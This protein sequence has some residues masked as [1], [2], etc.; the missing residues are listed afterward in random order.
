LQVDGACD[1]GVR[2]LVDAALYATHIYSN[3]GV[4]CLY[5]LLLKNGCKSI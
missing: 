2:R 3:K 5:S 4:M 1:G